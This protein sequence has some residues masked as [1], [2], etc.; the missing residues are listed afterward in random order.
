MMHPVEK[1][2][3]PSHPHWRNGVKQGVLMID[4]IGADGGILQILLY[5]SE[6]THKFSR[7]DRYFVACFVA[8]SMPTCSG[9]V[10]V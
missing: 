8:D 3:R 4:L 7:D 10:A 5:H 2:S 6:I 1:S 9:A